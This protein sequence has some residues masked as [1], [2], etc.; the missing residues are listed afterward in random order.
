MI[1][2]SQVNWRHNDD[3]IYIMFPREWVS[4]IFAGG[5][6]VITAAV[7]GTEEDRRTFF[8]WNGQEFYLGQGEPIGNTTENEIRLTL[9]QTKQLRDVLNKVEEP[10]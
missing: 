2:Q 8:I 5:T 3:L 9:A 10:Q 1:N 4:P 6:T 7:L